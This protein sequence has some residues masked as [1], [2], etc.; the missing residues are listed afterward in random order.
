MSIAQRALL[1]ARG[2]FIGWIAMLVAW[3][4]YLFLLPHRIESEIGPFGAFLVFGLVFSAMYLI[5]FL[6]ITAPVYFL[7]LSVNK[8]RPSGRWFQTIF[9]A[10]LYLLS[11]AGWCIAYNT[12]PEW[13]LY[14]LAAT[15]GAASAYAVSPSHP[16]GRKRKTTLDVD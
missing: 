8:A 7:L 2:A 16:D 12:R 5:N 1:L 13:H 10:G 3:A 6:L 11:V 15:A 4:V 14:V 9:S